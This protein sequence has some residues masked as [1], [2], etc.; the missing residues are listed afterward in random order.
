MRCR[1]E[2]IYY[3]IQEAPLALHSTPVASLS[4]GQ[5]YPE[6]YAATRQRPG[7]ISPKVAHRSLEAETSMVCVRASIGVDEDLRSHTFPPATEVATSFWT[8]VSMQVRSV[9]N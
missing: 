8:R 3:L 1:Q 6:A 4:P 7:Q 2:P 5:H 9:R